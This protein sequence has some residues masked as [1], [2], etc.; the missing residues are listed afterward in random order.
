MI[1]AGHKWDRVILTSPWWLYLSKLRMG[2]S[3]LYS[4]DEERLV[5]AL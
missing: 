3:A 4:L 2:I 5:K 1:E